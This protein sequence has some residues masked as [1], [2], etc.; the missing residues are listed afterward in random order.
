MPKGRSQRILAGSVVVVLILLVSATFRF[1]WMGSASGSLGLSETLEYPVEFQAS[2]AHSELD[3]KRD[4]LGAV[5][6]ALRSEFSEQSH[7]LGLE[8]AAAVNLE[9]LFISRV[10]MH[11]APQFDSWKQMAGEYAPPE[12]D[13][14]HPNYEEFRRVWRV[15]ASLLEGSP[16]GVG[17][18]VV[19]HTSAESEP[20]MDTP[21]TIFMRSGGPGKHAARYPDPPRDARD[22]EVVETLVPMHYRISRN[23]TIPVT[24]SFRFYREVGKPDWKPT[25]LYLYFDQNGFGKG[26]KFPI[27]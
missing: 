15:S 6:A 14:L 8:D 11:L 24:V 9:R 17:S 19:R 7:S 18:I 21:G 20:N 22:V 27:N 4:G 5:L 23:E 26:L 3:P 1:G 25:D 16:I 2:N 12:S 10:E 13:P